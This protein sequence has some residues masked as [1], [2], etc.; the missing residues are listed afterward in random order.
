MFKHRVFG[1]VVFS[2]ERNYYRK[3]LLKEEVK[4]LL[5]HKQM[6]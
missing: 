2:M 6:R 3:T 1:Y 5:V 4:M